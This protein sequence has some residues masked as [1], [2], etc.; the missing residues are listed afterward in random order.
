MSMKAATFQ[1]RFAELVYLLAHEPDATAEHQRVVSEAVAAT[2]AGDTSLATSQLNVD[3]QHA[4]QSSEGLRLHEL[5]MRM[6]AH[7]AHQID[8]LEGTPGDQILGVAR[9]L[10]AEARPND[11][12]V[13]FDYELIKVGVTHV[14]VHLGRNGFV[15]TGSL[16]PSASPRVNGSSVH[17]PAGPPRIDGHRTPRGGSLTLGA[18]IPAGLAARRTTPPVGAPT[19]HDDSNR[20]F[21]GAFKTKSLATLSDDELIE[22]LRTE[23]TPQNVSR[24]LDEVATVAE[25]RGSDGRWEVVARVFAAFVD[26]EVS[27][28]DAELR[29]A[30][31]IAVRRLTKPTL[32]RGMAGLL[33]RR[34]ELRDSLQVVFTRLGSDAAEAL[35]DL[36]TSS[37]SLTDRRAY[38][39]VLAKIRDAVPTL[40]HLLGDNRWYVV[41]NAIDLLGEMRAA[42]AE[43]ALLDVVTHREERVRRSAATALARLGTLRSIQAVEKMAT[44]PVPEV[45][46]HAM[47]GLGTVKSPRAVSVLARAL[48]HEP[49]QEV[50]AVILA[51]L[52]RQATDE[53][54]ARLTK[55][56]EPDGRLFKRKPTALRIAAVQA[57]VEANTPAALVAL[58]RFANDREREVRVAAA[59]AVKPKEG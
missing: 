16:T 31:T 21:E 55:A 12:G 32:I 23:V 54:V 44:D 8:F 24:V 56:A 41:R 46:V 35:I 37:D 14:E 10:A 11:E 57:L 59:R 19:I 42:E 27:A 58:R 34:R 39:A 36:L 18:E 30:Y 2:A 50:Q 26:R 28:E 6:S 17:T 33:P 15:R 47:Q 3:L 40:I 20:M 5:V 49:D 43:N 53:A 29:R 48:D 38:L 25:A 4:R 7:S 52:G 45:R 9:I 13:A 51:A 1:A 22:R